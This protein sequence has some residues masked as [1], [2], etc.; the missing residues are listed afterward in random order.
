MFLKHSPTDELI[1]VI[2]LQDVISPYSPTVRGRSHSGETVYRPENF[3]KSELV[4]PSGEPLPK[5]WIDV[6][7]YAHAAA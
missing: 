6:H 2:D 4:F 3:L 7:Y 5:C 1:E